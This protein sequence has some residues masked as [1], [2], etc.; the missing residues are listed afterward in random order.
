MVII[1]ATPKQVA[2][3]TG[4]DLDWKPWKA[5]NSVSRSVLEEAVK[6]DL[7][8]L[9]RYTNVAGL[10]QKKREIRA[11]WPVVSAAIGKLKGKVLQPPE[12]PKEAFDAIL[13][14]EE[15]DWGAARRGFS[16]LIALHIQLEL[17]LGDRA[18]CAA[19][20][21]AAEAF[22]SFL[23]RAPLTSEI[24]YLVTVSCDSV[25]EHAIEDAARAGILSEGQL[26]EA[27][28]AVEPATLADKQLES[29][30]AFEWRYRTI[31]LLLLMQDD[32]S[33][34]RAQEG[35]ETDGD[36]YT[37]GSLDMPATL[38]TLADIVRRKRAN[39]ARPWS[40][41]DHSADAEV[42]SIKAK[43]PTFPESDPSRGVVR[44]WW[45]RTLYKAR[46]SSIKNSI[47]LRTL[48]DFG[49][50]DLVE[51]TFRRRTISEA[52][53]L[54]LL[55][56]IYRQSHKGALPKSLDELIPLAG[57]A[58][59]PQDFLGGADFNYDPA[60]KLFWSVGTNGKDDGGSSGVGKMYGSDIVWWAG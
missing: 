21:R 41:Q 48:C 53:R 25:L 1:R 31:P 43:L 51:S 16:K 22:H 6:P 60:R 28:R 3:I 39:T 32:K 17:A 9:T 46:M 35:P 12:I 4:S 45:D 7:V 19:A 34:E 57:P 13:D 29:V 54:T 11:T 5:D 52:H 14:K 50:V 59:L 26:L 2:K 37:I 15:S 10:V 49:E 42:A 8:A 47:G 58:G 23:W 40:A 44:E 20:V 24:A 18:R 55:L 27:Y 30:F 56:A 36:L 38:S 33:F